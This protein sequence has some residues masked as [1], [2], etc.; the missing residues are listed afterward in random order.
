MAAHPF[1]PIEKHLFR[2][3]HKGEFN[4]YTARPVF[5]YQREIKVPDFRTHPLW[6]FVSSFNPW[7]V[8]PAIS[9]NSSY[10]FD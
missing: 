4:P 8:K 3:Y 6:A 2:A 9:K 7:E 5:T 1:G 10:E